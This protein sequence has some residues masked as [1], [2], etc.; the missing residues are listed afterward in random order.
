[1]SSGASKERIIHITENRFTGLI[2]HILIGLSLFWLP[3]LELVP[4]AT[5]YGIFLY[6]GFVSLIGN[7]FMERLSLWLMDSS[8]Y[9]ATHYIRR[10]PIR[11]IHLYTFLQFVCLGVLCV[12]NVSRSE[13]VRI[14]FPVFIALLVPVRALAARLFNKEHLA[15]LDADEVPEQEESHWV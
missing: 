12:I 10:V 7:Q 8:L 4:M 1:M 13:T 9:P 5:L 2:I 3:V 11:V 15:V 6:M 14:I